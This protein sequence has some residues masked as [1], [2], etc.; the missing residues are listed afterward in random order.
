MSACGVA[1][2][3]SE[4]GARSRDTSFRGEAGR[5]PFPPPRGGVRVR[6]RRHGDPF[7]LPI[8]HVW[9]NFDCMSE[10]RTLA[11]GAARSLNQ[12]AA[13]NLNSSRA[14]GHAE[15]IRPE[16]RPTAVQAWMV[17]NLIR[18]VAS[19]GARPADLSEESSLKEIL[20]VRELY[21]EE[22][23][24]LAPYE[25]ERVKILHRKVHVRPIYDE[26]PPMVQ[27]Y[28]RWFPDMIE[29]DEGTLEREQAEGAQIR[30]SWDPRLRG[31]RWKR[32]KLYFRLFEQ[33]LLSFRRKI[34][35]RA[36][37]FTVRKKDGPQRLIIDA[38]CANWAHRSPPTT[39]LGSP[40]RMAELDLSDPRLASTRFGPIEGFE[41][42]GVKGDVG[43]CFYNYTVP[44]LAS[45]F[46][47]AD[48]YLV[49]DLRGMEV[50]RRGHGEDGCGRR[51][52][53]RGPRWRLRHRPG[54]RHR[55]RPRAG[56][57]RRRGASGASSN[58]A[59]R[60]RARPHRSS[61]Y[62]SV[63]RRLGGPGAVPID[64]PRQMAAPLGAHQLEGG[65]SGTPWSPALLPQ[66]E[67]FGPAAADPA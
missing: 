14:Q 52:R 38:R 16:L 37:I 13:A 56:L 44:E 18:R 62:P 65:A 25:F 17:C 7:P 36:G 30:P 21:S 48:T 66:C 35:S 5:G 51:L 40:R 39:R 57:E 31:C 32:T 9:E 27:G 3:G 2:G 42:A 55:L 67:K 29:K 50:L 28:L 12:L 1:A 64:L 59:C 20:G 33:G 41:P 34:K 23:K 60:A 43:D 45:W 49:S 53:G 61:Q 4:L 47:F 15:P 46:G 54:R 58:A 26:L 11:V 6:D 10:R 8:S 24:N 22:P 19:Y 63:G